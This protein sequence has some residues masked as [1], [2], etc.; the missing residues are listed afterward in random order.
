MDNNIK[1]I[2]FDLDGTLINNLNMFKNTAKII[3][4]RFFNNNENQKKVFNYVYCLFEKQNLTQT[5]YDTFS[6]KPIKDKLDSTIYQVYPK[7]A[8]LVYGAK[9]YLK[10]LKNNG[11]K[12][13]ILTNGP[14]NQNLKIESLNIKNMIDSV[15]I[16]DEY[17]FKKPDAKIYQLILTKLNLSPT[18]CVFVGDNP[19]TDIL[20]AV[21]I[22]MKSVLIS[23]EKKD[24][25]Q[26]WTVKNFQ[27][28]TKIPELNC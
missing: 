19:Q 16:S 6:F 8:K 28:L 23:K 2:I 13:G 3:N 20:G 4:E 24:F 5:I 18:E 1:A 22:D 21:N 14:L 10:K 17:G 7:T 15:V 12:I 11:V 25:G 26:T 9:S 27:E